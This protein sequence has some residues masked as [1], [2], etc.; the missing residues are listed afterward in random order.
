MSELGDGYGAAVFESE[1]EFYFIEESLRT[2]Q[3]YFVKG[4][5]HNEM[6][7]TV[8]EFLSNGVAIHAYSPRQTGNT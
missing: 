5:F 2:D 7:Y 4:S 3:D 6:L 8:T 1:Q